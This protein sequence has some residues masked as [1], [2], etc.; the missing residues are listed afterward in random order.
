ME[1]SCL[2]RDPFYGSIVV[3]WLG[4]YLSLGV[5]TFPEVCVSGKVDM[6]KL[7]VTLSPPFPASPRPLLP[8]LDPL[9]RAMLRAP[10]RHAAV[11]D[12]GTRSWCAEGWCG[13][14]G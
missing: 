14:E 10:N 4:W 12:P 9:A 1:D 7:D 11:F 3:H 8:R 2:L 5:P 6:W 13:S